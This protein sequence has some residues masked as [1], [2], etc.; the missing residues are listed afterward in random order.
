MDEEFPA[1]VVERLLIERTIE[2]DLT[3]PGKLFL[4]RLNFVYVIV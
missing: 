2:Q 1:L 4:V 3:P